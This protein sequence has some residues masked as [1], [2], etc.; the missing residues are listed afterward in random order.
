M[1]TTQITNDVIKDGTI[2]AVK[3]AAGVLDGAG[4]G[5]DWQSGIQAS[6]FTAVAG[7]GYFVNTTSAAITV[8]MPSSP[9]L[10][11][12]VNI[13]DYAGTANSN[14]ITIT[15]GNNITGSSL[16]KQITTKDG[17]VQL[18]YSDSTSGWLINYGSI[19][20]APIT[21][22]LL[23][24]GGGGGGGKGRQ[25]YA[26]VN[27][28]GG[29]GGGAGEFLNLSSLN[30][31]TGENYRVIVGAGGAGQSSGSNS[32]FKSNGNQSGTDVFDYEVY[33]GGRGGWNGAAPADQGSGG[34]GCAY[35]SSSSWR[36]GG[37]GTG[38]ET[39]AGSLVNNGGNGGSNTSSYGA[40]GGGGA[41]AAGSNNSGHVAGNGGNGYASS[42]TGSSVT[43]AGGGGGGTFYSSYGTGGTGGGGN[44]GAN[45][46]STVATDGTD[47]KGGGG[48]GGRGNTSA[49][50]ASGGD[51]V[52]ILKYPDSFTLNIG[53]SLTS[54][55]DSSSVSGFKIT[56]FTAGDDNISLS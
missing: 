8:T 26:N 50:G 10:G 38:L 33:G 35:G 5:V 43:Y 45:S 19:T 36:T 6:N 22:S 9:S 12:T 42:I 13:I 41:G 15:S 40:G 37:I 46:T 29:G 21:T 11:D 31:V 25:A 54:S 4:G 39:A 32:Q 27:S 56:T 47:G 44:G 3:L 17:S 51:G 30:L 53:S 2:T 28:L 7:K 20:D 49:A 55:T 16:D 48:G 14:A 52:V 24:I 1:A 18:V 34:G 23:I